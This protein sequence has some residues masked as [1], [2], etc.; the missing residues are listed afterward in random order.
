MVGPHPDDETRPAHSIPIELLK[1]WDPILFFDDVVLYESEPDDNGIRMLGV[2]TRVHES[3]CCC[4]AVSLCGS[5]ASSPASTSTLRRTR[6]SVS[7]RSRGTR[8][9]S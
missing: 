5:T 6:S 4:S 9:R 3:A 1:R 8:T 2:K 7:T